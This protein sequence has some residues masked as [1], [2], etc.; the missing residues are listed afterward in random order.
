M[1]DYPKGLDPYISRQY[2]LH[3]IYSPLIS[4]DSS[5]NS[6]VLIQSIINTES[7]LL[8]ILKCYGNNVKYPTPNQSFKITNTQLITKTYPSFPVRF[9]F[10]LPELLSLKVATAVP[11]SSAP[12]KT[13]TPAPKSTLQQLF[14]ISSLELLLEKSPFDATTDLYLAFFNKIIT[15]NSIVPFDTFNH[16]I[17]QIFVIDYHNDSIDYLRSK[18]VEFRN[19]TLPK[20]F[21]L[22]DLLFHAF[23]LYDQ[24]KVTVDELS[25]FETSLS[26]SLSISCT[27]IPIIFQESKPELIKIDKNENSTIDEDLQSLSFKSNDNHFLIPE[28]VDGSLRETVGDFIANYLIPHME[29]KI[30]IWDDQILAPKKSLTN[31]FFS[32]SKKLFN[33]NN[34]ESVNTTQYNHQEN[35]YH[36]SSPE[37]CIRK[38]ADW[39][40]ILKDFKYSYSIYDFI[41]KDYSN[42]KAWVYVASTQEMCIISLLL[43]QTQLINHQT[44]PPDKN[45]LRKIRHDIIEPYLDNLSYTYKSRLNLKTYNMRTM[46]VVVELLLCMCSTF[47]M[48][49]W[50]VDLIEKYL[51][52]TVQEFDSHLISANQKLQV[53]CAI[54]YERLGYVFGR[55][56][57]ESIVSLDIKSVEPEEKEE[58]CYENTA[59]L[60]SLQTTYNYG[61]SRFRKSS[62]WYLISIKQWLE[63]K[64]YEHIKVLLSNISHT[65][66]LQLTDNWY[67][68]SD[69]L[70]G[71]V[72][73]TLAQT[74]P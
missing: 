19:C 65:F 46:L 25:D 74:S 6:E 52:K 3:H 18:I 56:S 15:S 48:Y 28:D 66:E 29:K 61:L 12:S 54:I 35:Y 9:D 33:N 24:N 49:W 37:Q 20:F 40:L 51:T 30:R 13:A 5:P 63:L 47:K 70:L 7:S 2:L 43:V 62:A 31:R 11:S 71:H 4:V 38:L 72:K 17:A 39:S 60:K 14:S 53:I 64:R 10:P 26:K 23:I 59:K 44:V 32:V 50:W 68:R 73:R 55:C 16:P 45:T 21:Q 58:G 41:K 69:L 42:D 27:F 1:G 67:D 22:N 36:K 34:A 57:T 8:S